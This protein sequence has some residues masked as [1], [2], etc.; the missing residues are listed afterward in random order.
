MEKIPDFLFEYL[1]QIKMINIL[2]LNKSDDQI[3]S[4]YITNKKY[5]IREINAKIAAYKNQDKC[6][7]RYNNNNIEYDEVIEK[8][9]I[10]KLK[11]HYCRCKLN[12]FYRLS[13]DSY[14][15]TLDRIDN[16]KP[17]T[18]DNVVISCLECNLKRR[19]TNKDKFLFTRQL[20]IVKE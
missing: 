16:G 1:N 8:L 20:K 4:Q 10:S 19:T 18:L 2:F 7:N 17:H 14:Q 9:M 3:N 13:R 5:L 12:L 6:R 15:W 11:C